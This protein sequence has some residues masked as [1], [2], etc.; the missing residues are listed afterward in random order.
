M[1]EI[2]D[3]NFPEDLR[4][5]DNH[6]WL[7]MGTGTARVGITDY[8]Q[9]QLGEIVF[10][11]LPEVEDQF[12]GGEAFGGAESLKSVSDLYMPVSGQVINVNHQLEAAP[13]LVNAQPYGDGWIIEIRLENPAE[14]DA[15]MTSEG[16][17]KF[18]QE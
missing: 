7:R 13:T 2:A 18:I 17:L 6:V 12:A 11:D 14:L 16:Y 9:D 5:T 10:I 15:L 3:L 4:Y 8:A 1:T